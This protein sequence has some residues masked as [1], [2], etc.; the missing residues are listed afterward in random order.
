VKEAADAV[1]TFVSE[2]IDSAM[3]KHN[4]SQE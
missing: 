4:R 2:G 1:F 3:N